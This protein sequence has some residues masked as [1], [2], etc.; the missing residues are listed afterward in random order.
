MITIGSKE[1]RNIQ[2][3]VEKNKNDIEYILT[4]EGVL[5]EFGI[6]VTE[7]V[8]DISDLP[9]VDEYKEDHTGWEYGDCIAVGDEEPYELYILTRANGNH[10]NDYWFD[11]GVFPLPGPQGEQGIQGIQGETGPQG[12]TGATGATGEQG[13]AGLGI[14]P[15][16]YSLGYGAAIVPLT[17][18][19]TSGR[20]LQVGDLLVSSSTN[21]C[22]KVTS[23]DTTQVIT[24]SVV[25]MK[26]DKGDI[27]NCIFYV[28]K[29]AGTNSHDQVTCNFSDINVGTATGHPVNLDYAVSKNNYICYIS[30]VSSTNQ[31]FVM[32]TIHSIQGADGQDGVT[33]SITA[34][35]T[36]DSNTGTPT[37]TVTKSGT[38]ASPT[39][40][41]AFS[42]IKGEPGSSVVIDE[43]IIPKA[44]N[45]YVLGDNTHSYKEVVA[46][47]FKSPNSYYEMSGA[48]I[49]GHGQID[50]KTTDGQGTNEAR[51]QLGNTGLYSNKNI[52]PMSGSTVNLGQANNGFNNLYLDGAIIT[53]NNLTKGLSLPDTTGWS[54]NKTIATTDQLTTIPTIIILDSQIDISGTNP[55]INFTQAQYNLINANNVVIIEFEDGTNKVYEK[56]L[57]P[58]IAL[59]NYWY[60]SADNEVEFTKIYVNSVSYEGEI[61]TET[62]TSGGSGVTDVQVD[63]ISIVS[64]GIANINTY[65]QNYNALTNPL[66]CAQ[67]LAEALV[68]NRKIWSV[69]NTNLNNSITIE[70]QANPWYVYV[71]KDKLDVAIYDEYSEVPKTGDIWIETVDSA[72]QYGY[73]IAINIFEILPNNIN[74][75]ITIQRIRPLMGLYIDSNNT[76]HINPLFGEPEDWE[77][78]VNGNTITKK[79]RILP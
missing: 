7:Q 69:G 64:Q 63:S 77:F 71:D 37:V 6:R 20:N 36:V 25:Y 59:L 32:N 48:N 1:F 70:T 78:T 67:E 76:P 2:E 38:D 49:S 41:F 21:W 65:N 5:N 51:L 31:T 13:I 9:T 43:D 23:V 55:I 74:D 52:A 16:S 47:K 10:P 58:D 18:I 8:S 72:A 68:E 50:I 15:T 30:N 75:S 11:L 53:E 33:P 28:N 66:V 34:A 73:K 56:T 44:F 27:G 24:Q 29:D 19:T 22:H 45:T 3:Q 4:E 62:I 60:N 42:N 17:D 12:P 39:F 35:A 57:E 14:Y 26:G 40:T 54:D 61:Y 79:V 46:N